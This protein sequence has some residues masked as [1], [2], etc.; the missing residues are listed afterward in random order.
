[1]IEE[2]SSP[3]FDRAKFVEFAKTRDP[4]LRSELVED[5]LGLAR[6]LALRFSYQGQ[7]HDDL[8]Q[9]ASLGIVKAVDRFEPERGVAFSTYASHTVIGEL[10]RHFRDNGWA[11]RAPRRIQDLHAEV[12]RATDTLTQQLGRAPTVDELAKATGS[13][14]E[15]VI[16]AMEAGSFVRTSSLDSPVL[17]EGGT[18]VHVRTEDPSFAVTDNRG[19]LAPA[20]AHLSPREQTVL[21]LR[22]VDQCTQSEIAALIGVSQMHVSRLLA[23]SLRTLRV[24]ID[25]SADEGEVDGVVEQDSSSAGRSDV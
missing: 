8:M 18:S 16:E 2:A 4:A 15:A 5:H 11:I 1:M 6:Y 19:L 25:A 10:K 24:R 3:R 9:V 23:E 12:G 17:E 7:S 21:R 20:M 14:M 13:T 22:F